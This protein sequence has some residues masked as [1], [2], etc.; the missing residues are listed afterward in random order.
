[1]ANTIQVKRS[2]TPSAAPGALAAGELAVNTADK[3][4]FIGA[5][6]SSGALTID[7]SHITTGSINLPSGTVTVRNKVAGTSNVVELQNDQA[8]GAVS[9]G[10]AIR[11]WCADTG[12]TLALMGWLEWRQTAATPGSQ[13]AALIGAIRN[14]GSNSNWIRVN[15]TAGTYFGNSLGIKLPNTA[16]TPA[17]NLEVLDS[18]AP[19]IRL[20]QSFGSKY[21][22]LQC[23]SSGDLTFLHNG[24]SRLSIDASGNIAGTFGWTDVTTGNVS[25]SAHGLVPKAPNVIGQRLL[26]SGSWG[27]DPLFAFCSGDRTRTAQTLADVTDL[28]LALAANAKYRFEAELEVASSSAAGNQYAIQFSAAGATIEAQIIGTTTTGAAFQGDRISAFNTAATAMT[29]L[30]GAGIVRIAGMVETGGNA[31]NLTV[32]FL[33]VTS[34]TATVRKYSCLRADRKA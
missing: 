18:S 29:T 6:G 7:G 30:N 15:G 25:T 26:Y 19:Q 1:M 5:G 11:G 31:G 20:T 33:K 28:S 23:N 4:L 24:N 32:Q 2:S 12:G 10:V 22:E 21:V 27:F 9:D 17:R 34:G 16:D 14:A 3:R 8:T 13:T